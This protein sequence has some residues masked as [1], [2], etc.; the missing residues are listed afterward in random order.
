M[1]W[2]SGVLFGGA[3]LGLMLHLLQLIALKRHLRER[4]PAPRTLPPISVLKPLC[5]IDDDLEA[6]LACFASL[7]YPDYELV[8]GVRDEKDAA[9]PIACAA[10][11]CLPGRVRV[12]LQR[13]EP[14][15]NPKVNQL[16]TLA[17]AA[18]HDLLVVSDSNVAVGPG[19]LREIAAHLGDPSVGLVTH[20][21]VGVGERRLGALLDNL[22][23]AA[24]IGAGMIGAKRVAKQDVVVG[25]SMALRRCDLEALGGF[26]VVRDVLAED[27][28]LGRMV[29][30]RL[31]RRVVMAHAPVLNVSRDRRVRDF[32]A[33]YRRWSVLH[34]RAIGR[35]MYGAQL[36]LNPLVLALGGLALAP[37]GVTAEAALACA[38]AKAGYD[39]AA[40]RALRGGRVSPGRMAASPLK[41]L[42]LFVAWLNGLVSQSV[43]WRGNRLRV[44]DGTLIDRDG[45]AGRPTDAREQGPSTNAIP[46]GLLR[47]SRRRRRIRWSRLLPYAASR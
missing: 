7:D 12:V 14:G 31:G 40:L 43:K 41:D 36:L 5:G 45:L 6:N 15:M 4:A 25:K 29:P 39:E 30:E 8:L 10:A 1:I 46:A 47:R 2:A 3:A 22:H 42:L 17:A 35:W 33:R 13:G 18:R 16:I 27:Y 37:S 9:W 23:L 24:S 11:R 20:A 21:V 32:L 26:E 38:L 34:R 19:Y 28:V 44:L